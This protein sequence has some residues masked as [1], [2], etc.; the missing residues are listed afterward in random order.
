MGIIV[1]VALIPHLLL[2]LFS[3][4]M[5]IMWGK[6]SEKRAFFFISGIGLGLL[7]AFINLFSTCL[8]YSYQE[9]VFAWGFLLFML[10]G[11]PAR[12]IAFTGIILVTIAWFKK[13]VVLRALSLAFFLS[14][15]LTVLMFF[16]VGKYLENFFTLKFYY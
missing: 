2:F 6:D 1:L 11:V 7:I 12:L 10:L 16:T 8:Y 9:R 3:I 5:M 14:N 15:P 13:K 4:F